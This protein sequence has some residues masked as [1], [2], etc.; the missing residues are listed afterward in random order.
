MGV[1]IGEGEGV[2]VQWRYSA[3]ITLKGNKCF[4]NFYS[5]EDDSFKAR[6]VVKDC[7]ASPVKNEEKN[8]PACLENV[9]EF[10]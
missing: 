7:L 2:G 8:L 9:W 4:N 1:E 5:V 10:G 6:M 3:M